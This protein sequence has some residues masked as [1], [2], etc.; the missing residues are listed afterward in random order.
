MSLDLN[1][2]S[3]ILL[4]FFIAPGFVFTRTY[5][6]YRPRYYRQPTAFEQFVLA[7][8][9]SMVIH[10][11]LLAAV[12]LTGGLIW[13]FTGTAFYL[14]PISTQSLSSYPVPLLAAFFLT[15]FLYLAVTLIIARRGGTSLGLRTAAER[16]RWW[17]LLL[18]ADPPEPFLLWHT[19]LQIE[20]LQQ[21]L[22]PPHL[23]VQMRNGEF[24]AGDLYQLRLVGDEENTVEL[25]LRNVRHR[26]AGQPE[27]N[28]RPLENQI[29]L[30]KSADVLWLSR[31]EQ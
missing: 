6:A 22:I 28:L 26:P 2:E 5:T 20:P 9:G 12:A 4:L 15:S 25:A 24:F 19:V 18:G 1:L 10:T 8:V 13:L 23:K 29:V 7:I 16:P 21:D 14:L 17:Q 11:A 3:I 30:L 31:N 27:N